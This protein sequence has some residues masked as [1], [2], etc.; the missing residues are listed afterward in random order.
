MPAGSGIRFT[1]WLMTVCVGAALALA[2]YAAPTNLATGIR[3]AALVSIYSSCGFQPCVLVQD[4]QSVAMS[5]RASPWKILECTR[6]GTVLHYAVRRNG[7]I[8][9]RFTHNSDSFSRRT[10]L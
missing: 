7:R 6:A 8:R 10:N 9:H 5:H 2:A 3:L 1:V 4:R